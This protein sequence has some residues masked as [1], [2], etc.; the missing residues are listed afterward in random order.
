MFSMSKV[1]VFQRVELIGGKLKLNVDGHL[2]E[3]K[4][5]ERF[6]NWVTNFCCQFSGGLIL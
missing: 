4:I 1:S 5:L 3:A 6:N 2:L